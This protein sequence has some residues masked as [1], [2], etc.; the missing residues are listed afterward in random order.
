MNPILPTE[1]TIEYEDR[2]YL[3]PQI[4]LDE[5]NQFIENLRETQDNNIT[6]IQ[7]QTH[8]LGTDVPSS[9][10]G[11]TG[12]GSYFTSRYAT[13]QNSSTLQN[14]RTAAQ[15]T[16]LN[17]VLANEQAMWKKRY[18]DAYRAY[19][20][21]SWDNSKTTNPSTEEPDNIDTEETTTEVSSVSTDQIALSIYMKKFSEYIAQGFSAEE[22]EARAKKDMGIPS[23]KIVDSSQ[24]ERKK[25]GIGNDSTFIYTL[26]NGHTVS[27]DESRYDLIQD[28]SKYML[29]DKTTGETYPVGG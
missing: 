12:P 2:L 24:I 26:P 5:S 25:S 6:Q 22:A 15:A 1:E 18:D 20:K 19:Q 21:R 3:N 17:Q 11:L 13:P 10:S 14:L 4:G 28:G 16:A 8:R 7:N 27:V 29:R 23:E 9:L